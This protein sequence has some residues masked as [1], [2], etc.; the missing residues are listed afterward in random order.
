MRSAMPAIT[1]SLS[2]TWR[3]SRA[4][5][6]VSAEFKST[7]PFEK[8]ETLIKS[9]A[10]LRDVNEWEKRLNEAES[11]LKESASNA[12]SP[13]QK[14][15]AKQYQGDLLY[16]RGR[17]YLKRGEDDRLTAGERQ[18][19]ADEARTLLQE[20][21]KVYGEAE[22]LLAD[23]IRNFQ[24]DPE[25]EKYSQEKLNRLRKTFTD[26]K[27]KSP[28]II[29]QLAD[30]YDNND[31]KRSN[32]LQEA[33][34]QYAKLW[35]D[36]R[37]YPAGLD[38]CYFAARCHYQLKEYSTA[39]G[40]LQEILG[41]G[42][43]TTLQNIQTNA[44]VLLAD[45]WSN[46]SPYPF[47]EVIAN[48]EPNVQRL[49]RK[50]LRQPT[51]LRIELELAKAYREKGKRMAD[52]G[53]RTAANKFNQLAVRLAKSISRVAS[54]YRD[55]AQKL[56]ADWNLPVDIEQPTADAAP[57]VSFAD[58]KQKGSDEM[59]EIE[60]IL[61]D[62]SQ[63]RNSLR[64]A[65]TEPQREEIQS[66]LDDTND[67]L[68]AKAQN[69]LRVFDTALKLADKDVQRAEINHIRYLQCVCYFAMRRYL[70]SAVIGEFLLERYPTVPGTRQA[71]GLVVQ[72]YGIM[73][74]EAAENDKQYESQRL[75]QICDEVVNRYPGTDEAVTAAKTMTQLAL[76]NKDFEQAIR[77]FDTIPA[78]S[79]SRSGLSIKLGQ[80]SWFDY[81]RLKKTRT[82]T[83]DPMESSQL[84]ARL[85]QAEQYLESGVKSADASNI[86]Y[87]TALGAL[88]LVDVF[89][90]NGELEKAL[91]Q[92]E[93]DSV[94]PLDLVKQKHPAIMTSTA[95]DV[96]VGETYKTAVKT[97]LA[98]LRKEPNNAI[99]IDKAQ[100]VIRA[101]RESAAESA[102]PDAMKR[103]DRIYTLI[104]SELKEQFENITQSA[105]Q[106][107]FAS[108]LSQLLDSVD[109]DSDDP[110][111]LLWSGSTMT[112]VASVLA[113]RSMKKEASPLFQQALTALNRARKLG[114]KDERLNLELDRQSAIAKRGLG[115]YQEAID[116]IKTLLKTSPRE[117]NLQL[118]A[119]ET[120][121]AWGKD[122]RRSEALVQALMGTEP[123][124]GKNNRQT[125]LI[126][127]WEK[128]VLALKDNPSYAGAYY[129]SLYG[130]IEARFEYGMIKNNEKAKTAAL[131]VLD[132]A[133]ARDSQLGGT[134]WKPKFDALE[135]KIKENL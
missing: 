95:A 64:S 15:R 31:P 107:K 79:A 6:S 81:Q 68:D 36:Y 85:Q 52:D 126:W 57:V 82:S 66:E 14:S 113:D 125:N 130:L 100:G 33:A 37:R 119:A 75:M 117:L 24:V 9:V 50:Q 5:P 28:L 30:T 72:S 63:L 32:N 59:V 96:Y 2:I 118:D 13:E 7:L 46:V 62:V 102:D 129:Q 103:V 109:K 8:A 101:M 17:I 27:I 41:L 25:D 1:M 20:S 114:L 115:Q 71:A 26:I 78:T 58:A 55:Q 21:L 80:D 86:D 123:I 88:L 91:R 16:R 29:E 134:Q 49:N 105:E 47:D 135:S 131:K 3:K 10:T 90:E 76:A 116:D 93:Q 53:D 40:Y 4:V 77:Y 18:K 51:W 121:Q 92:L 69:A 19:L 56:L 11:L 94:A 23:V 42:D 110:K 127:G 54:P 65:Q 128:L 98:A 124:K 99:W 70:E 38:A 22:T 120:L 106:A 97:Y 87:P 67:R 83:P 122:T 60:A 39:I 133:R 73:Y 12:T 48:F 45:C 84:K 43:N 132:N 108:N 61:A 111:I 89:L 74:D 44:R 35:D 34:R 104:A 112:G